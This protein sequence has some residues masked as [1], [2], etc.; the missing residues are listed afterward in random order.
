MQ[1]IGHGAT[2]NYIVQAS[3]LEMAQLLGFASKKEQNQNTAEL[4]I[5]QEIDLGQMYVRAKIAVDAYRVIKESAD[6]LQI[7]STILVDLMATEQPD[8]PV[9]G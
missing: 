8:P 7:T 4:Q 6:N 5:G 9:S 2:G 3:D 1:I